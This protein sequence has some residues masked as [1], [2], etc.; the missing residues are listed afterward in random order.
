MLCSLYRFLLACETT[1]PAR[2]R[3]VVA[4]RLLSNAR[5]ATLSVRAPVCALEPAWRS[6]DPAKVR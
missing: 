2:V 5:E 6:A 4:D 1:L 3:V